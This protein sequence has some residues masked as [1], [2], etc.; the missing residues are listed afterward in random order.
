[1]HVVVI[2]SSIDSASSSQRHVKSRVVRKSG[3][4]LFTHPRVQLDIVGTCALTTVAVR[5][6]AESNNNCMM[7]EL[8]ERGSSVFEI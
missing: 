7:R 1:V 5:A 6:S 3:Q 4:K 2:H 8:F